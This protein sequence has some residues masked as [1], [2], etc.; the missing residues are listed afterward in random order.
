MKM[1]FLKLRSLLAISPAETDFSKRGFHVGESLTRSRLERSAAA[2]VQ[3]YHLALE[4]ET[5]ESLARALERIEQEFRGF[6]YEGTGMG[7]ALLDFFFPW[8][9]RF[10]TFSREQ[11]N[12]HIYMLYVGWGWSMGRLPRKHI[13]AHYDPLLCWLAYDGYGFHEGFFSTEKIFVRQQLPHFLP[14]G[15]ARRAFDQGVGRSLWFVGCGD[16]TFIIT[17]IKSFPQSRQPDIWSGVGLACAYAGGTSV[18]TLHTLYAAADELRPHS[19]QGVAFAVKARQRA[20]NMVAH[21][22]Q[23][24]EIFCDQPVERVVEIVDEMLRDLPIHQSVPAFELWRERI[25][26][27]LS[28]SVPL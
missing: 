22:R 2:F 20:G 11:G 6:A 17:S 10:L 8:R 5:N 1:Q 7:L 25:R 26:T 9:K 3:G 16:P 19:V 4:S 12:E 13:N 15:Y 28:I 18:Q 24:C 23:A 21:T 27:S 14:H